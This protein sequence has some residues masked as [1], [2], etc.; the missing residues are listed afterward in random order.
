MCTEVVY[1]AYGAN[2]GPLQF[3]LKKILGRSTMPAIE[4]VRK[5]KEELG[6]DEAQFEL[7]AFIDGDERTGE[8][9]FSTDSAEFVAT[10]DRPALTLFQDIAHEPIPGFGHLG[11]GL[12]GMIVVVTLGNLIHYARK[13]A[14]P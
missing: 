1:R 12:L 13:P 11:W 2:Q 4:I 14:L 5:F 10:L 3:P 8:T 6:G 7:V 9:R